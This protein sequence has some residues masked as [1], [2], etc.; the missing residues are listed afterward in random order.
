MAVKRGGSGEP[1]VLTLVGKRGRRWQWSLLVGRVTYVVGLSSSE[2]LTAWRREGELKAMAWRDG[3]GSAHASTLIFDW[4][5][6][7][8]LSRWPAVCSWQSVTCDMDAHPARQR[9]PTSALT[10]NKSRLTLRKTRHDLVWLWVLS[11]D[12]ERSYPGALDLSIRRC[13]IRIS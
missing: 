2:Q 6:R 3:L 8:L 1:Y 11:S 13:A 10:F 9:W 4:G 7:P 12:W 5:W